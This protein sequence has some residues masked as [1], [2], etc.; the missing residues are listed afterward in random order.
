MKNDLEYRLHHI[1]CIKNIA[2]KILKN[3][4]KI[5]GLVVTF[6]TAADDNDTHTSTDYVGGVNLCGGLMLNQITRMKKHYS[7]DGVQRNVKDADDYSDL[8]VA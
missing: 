8:E 1:Q 6:Q 7:D 5:D 4:D 3:A 2:E